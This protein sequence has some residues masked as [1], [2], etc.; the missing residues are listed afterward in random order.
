MC[1]LAPDEMRMWWEP[2]LKKQVHHSVINM[3]AEGIPL[4]RAPNWQCGPSQRFPSVTQGVN[5]EDVLQGDQP[6]SKYV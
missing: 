5:V 6:D 3:V 2:L 4:A 1:A